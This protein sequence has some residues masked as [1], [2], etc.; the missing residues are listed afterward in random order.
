M[1]KLFCH[2][3]VSRAPRSFHDSASHVS[4]RLPGQEG[5]FLCLRSNSEVYVQR[6][7]LHLGMTSISNIIYFVDI[8]TINCIL[9]SAFFVDCAF[10]KIA[11]YLEVALLVRTFDSSVEGTDDSGIPYLTW[12]FLFVFALAFLSSAL[13]YNFY[14]CNRSRRLYVD[15][16]KPSTSYISAFFVK[17]L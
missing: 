2:S 16:H 4:Y 6:R 17:V 14:Q 5:R 3:S 8:K 11:N 9:W 15:N 1:L 10:I 12:V 7:H 13:L